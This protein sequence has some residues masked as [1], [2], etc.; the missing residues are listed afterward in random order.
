MSDSVPWVKKIPT[1]KLWSETERLKKTTPKKSVVQFSSDTEA[2]VPYSTVL[3]L[4]I[5]LRCTTLLFLFI[6]QQ[7]ECPSCHVS[8]R[9][10]HGAWFTKSAKSRRLWGSNPELSEAG[11]WPGGWT[12]NKQ[13]KIRDMVKRDQRKVGRKQGKGGIRHGCCMSRFFDP[14]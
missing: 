10:T 2:A 14:G 3:C 5:C 13:I 7:A 6:Y 1:C 8:F 4:K 11:D 12:K 9:P